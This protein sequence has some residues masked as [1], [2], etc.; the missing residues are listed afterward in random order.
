MRGKIDKNGAGTNGLERELKGEGLLEGGLEREERV[1][2][3][4]A[5]EGEAR[6]RLGAGARSGQN[7]PCRTGAGWGHFCW[8]GTGLETGFF[9]PSSAQSNY[10]RAV[11]MF[12]YY[13]ALH[14]DCGSQSSYS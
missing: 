1:I 11:Y 7:E 2:R 9:V 4:L 5:R 8:T 12:E 13:S 6:R 14:D 3:N 10:L